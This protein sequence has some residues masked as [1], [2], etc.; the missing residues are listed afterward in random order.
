MVAPGDPKH[1]KEIEE[2]TH[3]PVKPG[4][5]GKKS[6]ER[7][8]MNNDERNLCFQER[9]VSFFKDNGNF[10][11]STFNLLYSTIQ[12]HKCCAKIRVFERKKVVKERQL[13]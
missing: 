10:H 7:K 5:T 1:A 6:S 13:L 12:H 11:N 8:Q 9:F 4:S 2:G 3:R